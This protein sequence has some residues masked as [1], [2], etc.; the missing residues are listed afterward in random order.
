M[1]ITNCA[2]V[3]VAPALLFSAAVVNA[4]TDRDAVQACSAA[5]ATTIE[6][7][8]GPGVK[9]RVDE[10]GINPGERLVRQTTFEMDALDPSTETVVGKFSC[11][12]DRDAHV[13][14]LRTLT[15]ALPL[16]E[17]LSRR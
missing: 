9:I 10:S 12:V 3:L 17:R 14:K 15:L 2:A 13:M 4:A 7:E 8:Q 1:K 16:A 6:R 5:I 11:R